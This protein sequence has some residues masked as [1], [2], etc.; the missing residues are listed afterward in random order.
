ML[1][2][3]GYHNVKKNYKILFYIIL[4]LINIALVYLV[5]EEEEAK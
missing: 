5:A 4:K 3:V 2:R 1:Y